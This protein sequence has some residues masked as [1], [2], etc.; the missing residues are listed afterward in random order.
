MLP[1]PTYDTLLAHGNLATRGLGERTCTF[2]E[3]ALIEQRGNSVLIQFI[4]G[5]SY[6]I[7]PTVELDVHAGLGFFEGGG[8]EGLVG[9]GVSTLF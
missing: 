2:V 6:L 4:H 7:A 1:N 9:V 5:Y 3:G 8:G